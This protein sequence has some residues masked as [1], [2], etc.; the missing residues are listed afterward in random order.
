MENIIVP[1]SVRAQLKRGLLEVKVEDTV[2]PPADLFG[3]AERRNP[4]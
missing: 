1:T 2:L 4:K 3:F